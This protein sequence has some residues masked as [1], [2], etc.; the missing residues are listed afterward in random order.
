[1]SKIKEILVVSGN[2]KLVSYH[3][4]PIEKWEAIDGEKALSYSF[5][6]DSFRKIMGRT[7]TMIDAS[8][9]DKQKNKAMK[10]IVR[11]IFGDEMEFA[12]D[13]IYDQEKLQK[14]A[15]E[16]EDMENLGE[17]ISIEEALGVH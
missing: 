9:D 5:L 17:P 1:M 3:S 4:N 12:A 10:D 8:I 14:L 13:M 16:P 6:M 7:L 2:G 11:G 15:P